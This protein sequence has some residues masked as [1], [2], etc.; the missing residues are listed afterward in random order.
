MLLG[1]MY[2]WLAKQIKGGEVLLLYC[3]HFFPH[4]KSALKI[5]SI[6]I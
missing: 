1:R 2:N 4:L 5:Y 6:L 3:S